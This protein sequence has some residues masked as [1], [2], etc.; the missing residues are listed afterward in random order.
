M[1][2]TDKDLSDLV[3]D[4]SDV[5]DRIEEKNVKEHDEHVKKFIDGIE[6]ERLKQ[7]NILDNKI[8]TLLSSINKHQA[9]ISDEIDMYFV[10]KRSKLDKS[11][12]DLKRLR[13]LS[14]DIT[15]QEVKNTTMVAASQMEKHIDHIINEKGYYKASS[16]VESPDIGKFYTDSFNENSEKILDSV[17]TKVIST[18]IG[19]VI[20]EEYCK[21]IKLETKKSIIETDDEILDIWANDDDCLDYIALTRNKN[22]YYHKLDLSTKKDKS[23]P[24]H[25]FNIDDAILIVKESK[26]FIADKSSGTIHYFAKKRKYED[27]C[28]WEKKKP[29]QLHGKIFGFHLIKDKLVALQEEQ[30]LVIDFHTF[31]KRKTIILGNRKFSTEFANEFFTN[32]F[33]DHCILDSYNDQ[34]ILIDCESLITYV[35]HEKTM[36]WDKK[37]IGYHTSPRELVTFL[38]DKKDRKKLTINYFRR[39]SV[40]G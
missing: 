6:D 11:I 21:A 27:P 20:L 8:A 22:C 1:S 16:F 23:F 26:L 13:A 24:L 38:A 25:L 35:I 18:K 15:N 10:E 30:A 40:L 33:N 29:I 37:F 39:N 9:I 2:D 36:F 34:F 4:L 14:K 7:K 17:P 5:F 12:S 31:E 3:E 19:Y 32:H 28:Y